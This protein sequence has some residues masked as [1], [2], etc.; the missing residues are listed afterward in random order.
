MNSLSS[1]LLEKQDYDFVKEIILES[2]EWKREEC[3]EEDIDSYVLTYKM[4]NGEWKIWS[5]NKEDVGVSFV[6]E[7]SPANEKP[8]IGTLLLHPTKRL[9]GIGKKII[10]SI[11]NDLRVKG[12]KV[13][14]V[15][16]PVNQNSWLE[17][18]GKCGFEQF[19]VETEKLTSKDYMIAVKPL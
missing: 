11:G 14:F 6:I 19:K 13:L 17:F 18:I 15:G 10:T 9:Q 8:W 3:W 4:Y 12:H 1:R 5:L 7:W 16:C 2:Q